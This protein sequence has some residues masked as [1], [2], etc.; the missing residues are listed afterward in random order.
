M[1]LQSDFSRFGVDVL[2]ELGKR[3][4]IN[5]DRL[6]ALNKLNNWRNAFAHQDFSNKELDNQ[7]TVTLKKAQ[8]WRVTC[9][10]LAGEIDTVMRT[11]LTGILGVAPW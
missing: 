8:G 3:N 1:N 5:K 7:T 4:P 6:K 9:D 10:D 11:Y 2:D